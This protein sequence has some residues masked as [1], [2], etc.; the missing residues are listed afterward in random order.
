MYGYQQSHRRALPQAE[1]EYDARCGG[2]GY[3]GYCPPPYPWF[4]P[5]CDPWSPKIDCDKAIPIHC[6]P[7]VIDKPGKYALAKDLVFCD[8][9]SAND[10]SEPVPAAI[11]I[12]VSCVELDFCKHTLELKKP[13]AYGV[14]VRSDDGS[15]LQQICILNG[16]IHTPI[17]RRWQTGTRIRNLAPAGIRVN[18]AEKVL[19]QNMYVTNL[20]MGF[21]ITS[22]DTTIFTLPSRVP[23]AINKD[24]KI[25]SCGTKSALIDGYY[26]R[27]ADNFLIRDCTAEITGAVSLDG[28][29]E[30][31]ES[32]TRASLETNGLQEE[33]PVTGNA[34]NPPQGSTKNGLV[35]NFQS[36]GQGFFTFQS[37]NLTFDHV[38]IRITTLDQTGPNGKTQGANGIQIGLSDTA[39][40]VTNPADPPV[41]TSEI[42]VT[43]SI[44]N[45][46]VNIDL[47]HPFNLADNLLPDQPSVALQFLAGSPV[48]VKN[49]TFKAT[50][51]VSGSPAGTGSLTL[52]DSVFVS[53]VG[54]SSLGGVKSGLIKG[55]VFTCETCQLFENKVPDQG[56]EPQDSA[57]LV[58][59]D[60]AAAI[61]PI[62]APG[63]LGGR[64]DGKTQ[65][66][67]FEGNTVSGG[68]YGIW[69]DGP[70]LNPPPVD[71]PEVLKGFTEANLLLNNSITK[72]AQEGIFLAEN[73]RANV[74]EGNKIFLNGKGILDVSGSNLLANNNTQFNNTFVCPE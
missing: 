68:Y 40:F 3:G 30:G 19:I 58:L 9:A 70:G 12:K 71:F 6:L 14:L 44:L 49:S 56:L 60:N 21:S 2:K 50:A 24:I 8:G 11:T 23:T 22:G 43:A 4:P 64:R 67:R 72:A 42:P 54:G 45:S 10:G 48:F 16:K 61:G 18:L 41:P 28:D 46:S 29:F 63:F 15:L 17:R 62:P 39:F 36:K 59:G 74:L 47:T 73:A 55:N 7:F 5:S 25:I 1:E 35:E 38:Q 27:T 51:A 33:D 57:A 66:V 53:R 69:M 52:L 31:G 65:E 26:I 13:L 34:T 37:E 20:N 32:P